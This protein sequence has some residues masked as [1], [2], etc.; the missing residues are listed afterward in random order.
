MP[1]HTLHVTSLMLPV[2]TVGFSDGKRGLP[3]EMGPKGFIGDPGIPAL[4]PGPPGTDGK[5]GPRGPPGP[6]GLPG[7]DGK[8]KETQEWWFSC[9]DKEAWPQSDLSWGFSAK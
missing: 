7:P 8:W 1:T 4:Y 9:S 2:V 5:P 6:P 3:G